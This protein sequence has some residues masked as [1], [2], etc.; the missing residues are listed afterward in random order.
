MRSLAV[1]I[2]AASVTCLGLSFRELGLGN[3]DN[4]L[5]LIAAGGFGLAVTEA[6]WK[7]GRP[8]PRLPQPRRRGWLWII[9]R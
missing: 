7:A 8:R 6:L 3:M 9:F 1:F 4:G 2:G 5:A